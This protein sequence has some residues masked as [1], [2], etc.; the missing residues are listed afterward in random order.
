[1]KCAS[2]GKA[3]KKQGGQWVCMNEKCEEYLLGKKQGSPLG[4]ALSK[5]KPKNANL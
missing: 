2:C 5:M 4:E 3:M 1:M